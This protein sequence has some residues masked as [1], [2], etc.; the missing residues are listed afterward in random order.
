MFFIHIH[1]TLIPQCNNLSRSWFISKT[2]KATLTYYRLS[3]VWRGKNAELR[4]KNINHT[5]KHGDGNSMLYGCFSAKGTGWLIC[6]KERMNVAMYRGILGKNLP[7]LAWSSSMIM[8]PNTPHGQ[9]RSGYMKSISTLWSGLASLSRP[10][11]NRESVEGPLK[12]SPYRRNMPFF[13]VTVSPLASAFW[14]KWRVFREF[15]VHTNNTGL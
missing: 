12:G 10:Q 2:Y 14:V 4:P 9:R 15:L 5:V 8:I 6:I 3:F 13:L 11:S 1:S 7:S